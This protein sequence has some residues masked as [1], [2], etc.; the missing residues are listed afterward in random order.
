MSKNYFELLIKEIIIV[1]VLE[2]FEDFG[3]KGESEERMK[4]YELKRRN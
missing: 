3:Y 1:E 4:H 2:V